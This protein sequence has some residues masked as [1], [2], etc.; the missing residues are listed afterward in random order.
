MHAL[1]RVTSP[2]P[3]FLTFR[4]EV[5]QIHPRLQS[6]KILVVACSA[7]QPVLDSDRRPREWG[8]SVPISAV[9]YQ[10]SKGNPQAM[11]EIYFATGNQNKLKEVSW[12]GAAIVTWALLVLKVMP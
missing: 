10:G 3:G 7:A 12:R 8:Q 1:Q 5:K 11:R 6:K 4:P 9:V 2:S